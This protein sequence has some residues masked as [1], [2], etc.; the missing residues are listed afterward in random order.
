MPTTE[1]ERFKK[2][3]LLDALRRKYLNHV[4]KWTRDY[5]WQHDDFELQLDF[6]DEYEDSDPAKIRKQFRRRSEK[7][8]IKSAHLSGRTRFGDNIEDEWFIVFLLR[9]LTRQ[10]KEL[11]VSLFDNDGQFLL[12][13]AALALPRWLKPETSKNR[14]F[15]HGG[16]LHIVPI[17]RSPGEIYFIPAGDLTVETG[18]A[19]VRGT[20]VE[21]RASDAI[22]AEINKRLTGYPEKAMMESTHRVKCFIPTDIALILE[23]NPQM[24]AHAIRAFYERDLISQKYCQTM[25][26]FTPTLVTTTTATTATENDKDKPTTT[27]TMAFYRVRFTR[28]LYAQLIQQRFHPPKPFQGIVPPP[29]NKNYKAYELG[30]K[31]TCAFEM[32]YQNEARKASYKKRAMQQQAHSS[33]DELIKTH[34][35]DADT[36]WQSYLNSLTKLGY[37]KGEIKGSQLYRQLENEA[38]RKYLSTQVVSTTTTTPNQNTQPDEAEDRTTAQQQQRRR[39]LQQQNPSQRL[40]QQQQQNGIQAQEIHSSPTV[41]FLRSH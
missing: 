15:F 5:I 36:K 30:M 10:F 12:I 23:R 41:A 1:D 38:K 21:T 6:N 32:L 26:K 29:T 4:E 2:E 28:C 18:L 37:F 17:P 34:N 11:T 39:R 9:D 20:N 40:Q 22:Q 33:T 19:L 16:E 24:V 13:E 8:K 3:V 25:K 14:V 31:L 27:T 35:F 7:E